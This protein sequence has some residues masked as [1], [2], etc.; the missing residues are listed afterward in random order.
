MNPGVPAEI[1]S[2]SAEVLRLEVGLKPAG[3]AGAFSGIVVN[4]HDEDRPL[5]HAGAPILASS[6]V[7]MP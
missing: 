1:G 3:P 6:P 7:H 2:L 5:P 4:G